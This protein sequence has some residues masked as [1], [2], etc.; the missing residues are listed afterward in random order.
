[1]VLAVA[2]QRGKQ[3]RTTTTVNLAGAFAVG[4]RNTL[5]V[6]LD[7]RARVGAALGVVGQAPRSVGA[8]LLGRLY[9]DV[10]RAPGPM[11]C[12]P[13]GPLR[14]SAGA[15]ALDVFVSDPATSRD[16]ERAVA[17]C[18]FGCISVLG[19][20]L[21]ELRDRYDV[22][23]INTPP[24]VSALSTVA[25]AAADF[26]IAVCAPLL[27]SLPG[28]AVLKANTEATSMR[29]EGRCRP[30]FLGTVVNKAPCPS[31]RTVQET[32]FEEQ[33]RQLDLKTFATQIRVD[34]LISQA[35]ACGRPVCV[36]HP[37]E[38]SGAAYRRLACEVVA[39]I[40][41]SDTS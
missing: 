6:D 22:V 34:G 36:S 37:Q 14:A 41:Q 26:L 32:S 31:Q 11:P 23:L 25:M 2:G 35:F 17:L 18:G 30:G 39:R 24:S 28:V 3:G 7:L 21:S 40:Q 8:A 1:M 33:L 16:A 4:G 12:P 29:T 15:G 38:P 9:G 20:V 19:E 5:V 10:V 27:A 13:V